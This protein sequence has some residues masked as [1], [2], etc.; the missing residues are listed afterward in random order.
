MEY[1]TFSLETPADL[2][3]PAMIIG[4]RGWGNALE[5]SSDT[6]VYIVENRG[7]RSI[8][9]IDSDACYRYDES[10]PVVKIEAG[11][12]KSVNPPG[13][14]FFVIETHPA[15]SDLLILIADE[16][17]LNWYRF[18]NE[19]VELAIRLEAPMVITLGS[20]FD[21]VLHT[22]RTISAA[23]TG[24]DFGAIFQLH[25]VIP[26]DYTGPSA[27]HTLILDACRKRGIA[28]ASLWCHC[29]AYLQGITHHGLIIRLGGLLAEMASFELKT[30]DLEARWEAL[31]IQ[32]QELISENPKLEGIIDQIRKKKREGA[33]QAVG[34]DGKEPG[35]VI[36]LRDFLDT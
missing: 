35:K 30:D 24:G 6:A 18:S 25:G 19:L 22:D 11:D 12:L 21:Q 9:R 17:N 16:P 29:P 20:M 32:I 2:T 26:V 3:S 7:G 5:V 28:G 10:R 27:I 1:T 13:G 34:S 23:T 36:S 14:S 15:E 33:W 4:L 31:E 8:G